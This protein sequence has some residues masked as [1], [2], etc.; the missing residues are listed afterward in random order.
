VLLDKIQTKN[1]DVMKLSHHCLLP[2]RSSVG[3]VTVMSK[4]EVKSFAEN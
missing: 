4:S 1:K 2:S 3:M